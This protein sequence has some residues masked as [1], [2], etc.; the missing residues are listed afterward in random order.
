MND[1]RHLSRFIRFHRKQSHLSQSELAELA[2]VGK[3]A[4]YD[5]E[6][7]KMTVQLDTLIK[8]LRALNISM[9]FQSPLM[10][11]FEESS[12]AKS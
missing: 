10:A 9:V 5:I 12:D 6:K 4:V 11:A 3:T 2:G 7:G 8:V 1:L